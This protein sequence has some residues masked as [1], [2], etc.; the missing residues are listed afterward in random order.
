MDIKSVGIVGA[1]QMGNGIAHVFA[2]AGY[3]VL[4]SDVSEEALAAARQTI[5]GNMDR[6]VSRGRIEET[7]RDAA[8]SRIATTLDLP[9]VGASDLIIHF[10]PLKM[11]PQRV[12]TSAFEAESCPPL[13]K[14]VSI[15]A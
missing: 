4:L 5:S 6:Q 3:D 12:Q 9:Q 2:L 15:A 8:L 14:D 10:R 7:V 1:G 13:A 11:V